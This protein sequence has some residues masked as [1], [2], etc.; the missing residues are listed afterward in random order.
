[1][2]PTVIFG[3]L[4]GVTSVLDAAPY[5]RDVLHRTTRPHRGTWLIWSVL[6]VLAPHRRQQTERP[7]AS[8]WWQRTRPLRA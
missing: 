2:T 7:G 4:A 5:I 6:S 8:S 3:S 1:M